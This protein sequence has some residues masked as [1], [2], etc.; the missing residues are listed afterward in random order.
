M[1]TIR[2]SPT[3]VQFNAMVYTFVDACAADRFE[4]FAL[5]GSPETDSHRSIAIGR[6]PIDCDHE[7]GDLFE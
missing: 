3:E 5:S 7:I 4:Q 6:R 2:V 1:Q